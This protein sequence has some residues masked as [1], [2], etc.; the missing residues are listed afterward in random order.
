MNMKNVKKRPGGTQMKK[1]IKEIPFNA[2]DLVK[3]VTEHADHLQ[4]KRKLKLKTTVYMR[5]IKR[6]IINNMFF[7]GG[8][9]SKQRVID[10]LEMIRCKFLC[11]YQ[12]PGRP[13]TRRCDCNYGADAVGSGHERGNG[14]PELR[15]IV[16]ILKKDVFNCESFIGLLVVIF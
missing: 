15:C 8:L 10:I 2:E 11:S 12:F 3:S 14:C 1:K 9:E 13:P 4:G 5:K 7:G 16:E 6:P